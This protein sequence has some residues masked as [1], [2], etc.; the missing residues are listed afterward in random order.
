MLAATSFGWGSP[1]GDPFAV[2]SA[3]TS[4]ASLEP[5]PDPLGYWW[6]LLAISTWS[7]FPWISRVEQATLVLAGAQDRVAPVTAAR[8]LACELPNAELVVVDGEHWFLI[9]DGVHEAAADITEFVAG[10]LGRGGVARWF[11]RQ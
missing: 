5:S 2:W 6:Q 3:A 1:L 8:L 7:S 10:E 9:G 4:G 11:A